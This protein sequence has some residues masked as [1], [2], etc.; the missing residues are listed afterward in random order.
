MNTVIKNR[1]A[2]LEKEID[3]LERRMLSAY[4][5]GNIRSY[6]NFKNE[7]WTKINELKKQKL[8]LSDNNSQQA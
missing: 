7:Q 4:N 8:Y 1:I 3:I 5:S 6:N 2:E